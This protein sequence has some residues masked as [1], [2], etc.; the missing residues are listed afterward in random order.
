VNAIASPYARY[1]GGAS[2]RSGVWYKEQIS[3]GL[4]PKYGSLQVQ[5]FDRVDNACFD[6]ENYTFEIDE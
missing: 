5:I 2:P 4:F 3:G 6:G 1:M